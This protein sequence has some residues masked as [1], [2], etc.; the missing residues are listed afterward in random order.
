MNRLS[1]DRRRRLIDQKF[2]DRGAIDFDAETGAET[3]AGRNLDPHVCS[4]GS[5]T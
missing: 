1:A 5:T 3:G 2:H 4:P